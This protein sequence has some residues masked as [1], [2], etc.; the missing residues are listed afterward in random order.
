MRDGSQPPALKD[1][2]QRLFDDIR[3]QGR[4]G[5]RYTNDEVAAAIKQRNPAVRVSGAYLSAL[6]T[7]GKT[8]P[9]PDLLAALAEFFGVKPGYFLDP[10]T[11]E[12]TD[13]EIALAH[14]LANM[15]VRQIALRAARLEPHQRDLLAQLI[16]Q[17]ERASSTDEQGRRDDQ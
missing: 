11:A 12:E 14:T 6:R 7:G 17:M 1:R 16:D 9:S 13:A 2:L 5:R 4:H 3:P 8:R 10:V 15:G